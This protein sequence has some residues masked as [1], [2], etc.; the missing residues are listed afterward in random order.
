MSMAVALVHAP[1]AM[2]ERAWARLHRRAPGAYRHECRIV[3]EAASAS[4]TYSGAMLEAAVLEFITDSCSTDEHAFQLS[5]AG[6]RL[7]SLEAGNVMLHHGM[8]ILISPH[9]L[10][11]N[12][13]RRTPLSLCLDS[14]PDAGRLLPLRR[15]QHV[16]GRGQVDVP[17]ADPRLSRREAVLDVG[18]HEVRVKSSDRD[19]GRTVS[20]STGFQLGTTAYQ[21]VLGAPQPP[22][23]QS[24]PPP[25]APVDGRAPEGRHTMMLAFA[26]VP[27]VAGV[28]LVL[29]TG[30]WFFLLFSGAS[31]AV[32]TTIY[33]H[34]RRQRRR[35]RRARKQAADAWSEDTHRTLLSPGWATR[36]LHG[37]GPAHISAQAGGFPAVRVGLG[38]VQ[39][40]IQTKEE[41]K[42]EPSET[43]TTAVGIDLVGEET[44]T[45]SGPRRERMRLLRWIL[46]QLILNPLRGEIAVLGRTSA[47]GIIELRDLPTCRVVTASEVPDLH[48]PSRGSGVLLCTDSMDQNAAEHA[49]RVGWHV[50]IAQHAPAEGSPAGW[51]INLVEQ[52]V[53]RRC[54][55]TAAA[56]HA[57]SLG[58]DGLSDA[59][60]RELCRLAIPHASFSQTPGELPDRAVSRL[61][62]E[63]FAAEAAEELMGELGAGSAGDEQLDLVGDGPHALI[64]GT[65]GSGKSELLKTLLLS[66]CARY[67]PQELTMVL[68]DFKGGAAFHQMTRLE[69]VLGV[70]TDLSQAAT[71]RTIESIRSELVRR[72]RL[73]LSAGAGDYSEYRAVSGEPLARMLVVI[74]E[75]RI[76]AHELPHQLDELMRLA[77]LGRSLGLHLVLS[78]QRP[79]G[80]VTA[81]IRANIGATVALRMRGEDE[82]RDVI[83]TPAAAEISRRMPGRALLRRPGERPTELQTALLQATEPHLHAAPESSPTAAARPAPTQDA[84]VSTLVDQL[85]HRS[86]GRAHT[87]LLPPLPQTLGAQDALST[88]AGALL[89]RI[90]DPASQSQSD[91][92]L[93]PRH[94]QSTALIGESAAAAAEVCRAVTHQL[95]NAQGS[96]AVYLL[97]GDQSLPHLDGHP[98]VGARLSEEHMVESAH[99]LDRLCEELAARRMGRGRSQDPLVLIVTGYSQWL[100]AS[101]AGSGFE[102]QLSTLVA[103][104]P[105]AGISVLLAGGRELAVG[106]ISGRFPQRIYLP[107]GSGEDVTYLWPKLRSTDPLPGRGV[108]IS[109]TVASPGLALQLTTA[110]PDPEWPTRHGP[111]T[112]SERPAIE[113]RA[114]PERILPQRL[115]Q[116]EDPDGVVVGVQQLTWA[117]AALHLGPVNLIL[118]SPGT[119]KSSC[120]RLLNLKMPH[121]TL[122]NSANHVLDELSEVLLIDDAHRCTP[123]QHH[124]IQQAITAGTR[125]V[126]AAPASGAV[127]TQLPWAHP[128]RTQGSNVILSPVSRSEAESFAAIIPV[129]DRPVPGRAVHLRPEGAIVTQWAFP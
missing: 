4:D 121:A 59:T 12:P 32:A 45:I 67:S 10:P 110:A 71:E 93:N 46:L 74:D 94:P 101:Q 117:P 106:R 8:V 120:L 23:P 2:S 55:L 21:L 96:A 22:A 104:G 20:T 43:V 76:F 89:G 70:V 119:G 51:E 25:E 92:R 97:D 18:T 38:R 129:L 100:A 108:L 29:V 85:R 122:L 114:L 1:G 62:D 3:I 60:L 42:S 57:G 63:L 72:E 123:E 90:D 115:P 102:H 98:R 125:V 64:A 33:L 91:L 69:H 54:G 112:T 105:Q 61:P 68:V 37:E 7:G 52:T 75:F 15:G 99:L 82:S 14:G 73:F 6:F 28:V 27:L 5:T 56:H 48:A 78:T 86:L 11:L 24:W 16:I 128:A 83:G 30:H 26:L 66:L 126:A 39:A 44:T 40:Q 19:P 58:I 77:T 13:V 84:V 65:T 111:A 109:S 47:L 79:Q 118:G 50:V 127:F 35:Y 41:P 31:A 34:G 17:V 124:E 81:D 49:R 113:V 80:A 9:Q 95:L 53:H 103:E 116:T 36:L 88:E 87:P 107:F